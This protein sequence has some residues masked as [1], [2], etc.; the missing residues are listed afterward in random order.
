[1]SPTLSS[2]ITGALTGPNVILG[3][4]AYMSPE[5]ARGKPV[6]R[7]A[8][9]WAFGVL[10]FEMLTGRRLFDGETVSDTLAAV[11]RKDPEWNLLPKDTPLSVRR[12]LR[13]CLERNPG[14]RLR[15]IGDARLT[16]SE[17][18]SG[19]TD[20][21]ELS[22]VSEAPAAAPRRP[23]LVPAIAVTAA[24]IGL[25]LGM[26][27]SPAPPERPLRKY[28]M[29]FSVRS[30]VDQTEIAP[31]GSAICYRQAGR[32]W[33]RELSRLET[34]LLE[35]TS[36]AERAFWSPDGEWIG[37][38][39]NDALWRV[40]RTGGEPVRIAPLNLGQDMSN[41]G[42]SV[43]REDGEI[44]FASGNGAL[45]QVS[46]QGGA[47][48]E[49]FP[50][51]EGVTD[52]HELV[53]LGDDG[54]VIVPH[55]GAGYESIVL[56][57]PGEEPRT[58]LEV[59]GNVFDLRWSPQGYLLYRRTD[60][61]AGVWAVRFSREDLAVV[62][63]PFLVSEDAAA[64]SVTAG[65]EMAYVKSPGS[66]DSQLAWVG[67]DGKIQELLGPPGDYH[68]YPTLS[69]SESQIACMVRDG[70]SRNLWLVDTERGSRGRFTTGPER[71]AWGSWDPTG[72]EIWYYRE[73]MTDPMIFV[74]PASGAGEP[75]EITPG[76]VPHVTHDGNWLVFS[77]P[78][79]PSGFDLDICI[80]DLTTESA[81]PVVMIDS[82]AVEILAVPSPTDPLLAYTT[83]A[84]GKHEV[85]LTT[86]PVMRGNWL[87]STTSGFWPKWRADGRE[88]YM[89]KGDSILAVGVDP[90]GPGGSPRLSR[91]EFLFRRPSPPPPSGFFPHGFDVTG[92]GQRFV[93]HVLEEV[94]ER[95][96][97]SIV[98]VENWT[99]E[100]D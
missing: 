68:E 26:Q 62:G 9:I 29:E 11:L 72:R 36:G 100:F 78:K 52:F 60:D 84:N 1:M 2:P 6:D 33:V 74:R 55:V 53:D 64:V 5:Q 82:P 69:P 18:L 99:A 63:E 75:R 70:D 51:W 81:E 59:G 8:D 44:V 31:D 80:L 86:Y 7:R 25:V 54:W 65:G 76:W 96:P 98:V 87:V 23:W 4:A 20:Q 56:L 3:T 30:D 40:R 37:Y 66:T 48:R 24:A 95:E 34:R 35:G 92:D 39:A 12:L 91:P 13:R 17:V 27:L 19:V 50:I 32:L 38:G 83:N 10:F 93:M 45:Y 73:Q 61:A 90:E 88:L 28:Q 41:V 43:W 77:R 85:Y 22:L 89:T 21:E 57:V 14:E 46:A 71:H 15:D 47:V 67:R 42:R 16:L 49:I 58:L 97:P 94:E 79:G